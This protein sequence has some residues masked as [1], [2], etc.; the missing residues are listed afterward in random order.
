MI[1]LGDYSI[2][3]EMN[4]ITICCP[5]TWEQRVDTVT[6]I[7]NISML[8]SEQLATI[9]ALVKGLCELNGMSDEND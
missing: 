1:K 8:D 6:P 2:K 4:V 3:Q 5:Q 7:S 9:L